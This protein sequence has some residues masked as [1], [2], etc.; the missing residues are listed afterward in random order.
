MDTELKSNTQIFESLTTDDGKEL[1]N[2]YKTYIHPCP[3]CN[4]DEYVSYVV[5]GRPSSNLADFA[6]KTKF[7]KLGGCMIMEEEYNLECRKCKTDFN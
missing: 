3:K 4:T 5:R 1:F 7:V 2:E 6:Y